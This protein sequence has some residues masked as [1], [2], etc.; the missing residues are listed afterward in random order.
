MKVF[1]EISKDYGKIDILVNNAG[2][3]RG[4]L[5]MR[6]KEEDW[7]AVININLKSVFPMF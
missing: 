7:D 1:G 3:T 2:V 5:I 4:G 6:M